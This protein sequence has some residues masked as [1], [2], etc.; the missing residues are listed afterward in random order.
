MEIKE[1]FLN[2]SEGGNNYILKADSKN[3]WTGF[4]KKTID[5]LIENFDSDFNIVLWG[6]KSETDYY[7]IPYSALE[8]LFTEEHMT[9]G[10][11]A[12]QGNLRWTATVTDHL[13]KMHANSMF[14]VRIERFYGKRD[15]VL[16]KTY[17]DLDETFGVDYTI[18][19]A[20][21]N[22][23]IRL[24]QSEFRKGVM[25]NFSG[26]CCVSGISEPA[27]LIASHI[28]PWSTNKNFRS[29]PGNGLLLFVEYDAYFDKGYISIDENLRIVVTDRI[30]GLSNE[31]QSRL[32][33]IEGRQIEHP[34]KYKIKNEYVEYHKNHVLMRK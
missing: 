20:K 26:K 22:V 21:A 15:P 24:G 8:H 32:R 7:C 10:T 28:V 2:H 33:E 12:E 3:R 4:N 31:L 5:Q 9:K 17:D 16:I 14:S 34:R 13:F 25:D 23:K 11:L 6:S 19:D 27:M 29:D 1:I 18:E 30:A